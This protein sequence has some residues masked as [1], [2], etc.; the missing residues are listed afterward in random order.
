VPERYYSS[1]N[2]TGYTAAR[3]TAVREVVIA[4]AKLGRSTVSS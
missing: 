4:V 3:D 2:L 1:E